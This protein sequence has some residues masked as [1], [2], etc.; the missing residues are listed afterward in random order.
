MKVFLIG[1]FLSIWN[2][3][4]GSEGYDIETDGRLRLVLM[5]M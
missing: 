2:C 4:I 3:A 5:R 1:T